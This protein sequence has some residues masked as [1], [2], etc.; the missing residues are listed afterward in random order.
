MP[1]DVHFD[2]EQMVVRAPVTMRNPC[3]ATARG[4]AFGVGHTCFCIP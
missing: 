2:Q 3:L 1:R 4:M